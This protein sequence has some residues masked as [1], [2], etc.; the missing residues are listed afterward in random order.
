M[1]VAHVDE[2]VDGAA[3]VLQFAG[4]AGDVAPLD[5]AWIKH[6]ATCSVGAGH[7]DLEARDQGAIVSLSHWRACWKPSFNSL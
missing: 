1:T 7:A 2:E 4:N 6:W 5:G 3:R